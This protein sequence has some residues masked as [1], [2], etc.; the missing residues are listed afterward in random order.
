MS[1]NNIL[2]PCRY[3]SNHYFL[4]KFACKCHINIFIVYYVVD[5]FL[6]DCYK[7]VN[8]YDTSHGEK[9]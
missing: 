4:K 9:T 5:Y 8:E 6:G 3:V 2:C 1:E 7:D